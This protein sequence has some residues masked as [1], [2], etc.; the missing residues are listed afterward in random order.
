MKKN[1]FRYVLPSTLSFL[2]TGIYSIIDGF[3]VG[4][5]A[6]DVGLA[7]INIAWPLILLAVSYGTGIGMGGCVITSIHRGCKKE[8]EAKQAEGNTITLLFLGSILLTIFLVF[9]SKPF[10]ILFGATKETLSQAHI[11]TVTMGAGCIFQ[12][13]SSGLLPLIRNKGNTISAMCFMIIGCLCNIILDSIFVL[14]LHMGVKG[15]AIA[16]IISQLLTFILCILLLSKPENR[17]PFCNMKLQ[18]LFVVKIIKVALS[19]FG[20][21][22]LPSFTIILINIQALK[23]G[24]DAAVAAYAVIAYVT[25]CINFLIQG[26]S[27]GSQ[28]LISEYIGEQ[29]TAK[30]NVVKRL[31]YTSSITIG[32]VGALLI[33]FTRNQIPVLFGTSKEAS[34]MIIQAFPIFAAAYF[35]YGFCRTT[36]AYFYATNQTK[37]SSILVYGE[38]VIMSLCILILPHFLSLNGIW[39]TTLCTQIFLCVMAAYFLIKESA[40]QKQVKKI[41]IKT[42]K[43]TSY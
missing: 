32:I 21:T 40:L 7:A 26:I 1:F 34:A 10:L 23:Y 30:V 29:N 16:T 38:V 41:P 36:T 43:T 12:I 33:L 15:A 8:K 18:K 5:D 37:Y 9:A 39:A 31:T 4:K 19:P 42:P 6:G 27:D 2:L 11:Y 22:F 24:G 17:I 25:E 14:Y 20:L 35:F 3:F 13:M 28:P